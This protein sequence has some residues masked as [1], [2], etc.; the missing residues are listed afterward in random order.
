MTAPLS[1]GHASVVDLL[2]AGAADHPG[3]TALL[4]A[5][6]TWSYAELWEGARAA[7][8]ALRREGVGPG[9][10]VLIALPNGPEFLLA[11]F[12]TLLAGGIAVPVLSGSSP[13]RLAAMAELSGARTTVDSV[14]DLSGGGSGDLGFRTQPDPERPCYIQYTSGSTGDPRGVIITHQNILT[15]IEQMVEG[16]SLRPDDVFVTWL[17]MNHDMGL[18]LMGLTPLRLGARVVVLPTGPNLSA[19]WLSAIQTHRGTFTGGPDVAF[20]LAL[21]LVR[22]PGEFDLSSLRV[23]IDGSEPVRP[24]TLA[25]FEAAFG[26]RQVMMT[27]YGLAEATLTVT[28]TP[29]GR[30][31]DVDE[32][33]LVCLGPPVRGTSIAA[34]DGGQP[35]GPGQVGELVVSGPNVCAGYHHNP[36][37]TAD[38]MFHRGG[39]RFIHTGDLGY[40]DAS[41]RLYFV[42]RKKEVIKLGGRSLYP[43]EVESIVDELPEV[44]RSAAVGID[45]GDVA[46][47]QLFVFAEVLDPDRRTT[48]ELRQTAIAI[49]RTLHERLRVRPR[50]AL[51]LHARR[52]PVTATGK[53][54]RTRLRDDYLDGRL[55]PGADIVFPVPARSP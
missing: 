9:E 12:G 5:G 49:V 37:A 53:L 13:Q 35:V 42:S 32:R 30:P 31:I 27:G 54:Q 3:S 50:R 23:A 2:A 39:D 25:E 15:N 1:T 36:R 20:R 18:T 8:S 43:Q 45:S 55:A 26:L 17:P 4:S 16:M 19:R 11:F 22:H 52:I 47:E 44:R 48:A 29:R 24:S 34:I 28:C 21:R 7:G 14:G 33:G 6:R 41:G 51:L 10:L 46:G 40:L 38:L